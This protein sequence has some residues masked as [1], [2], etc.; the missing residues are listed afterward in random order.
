MGV[1][2]SWKLAVAGL[3][4]H[5]ADIFHFIDIRGVVLEGDL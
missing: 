3:F 4:K 5:L 2:G 1:F